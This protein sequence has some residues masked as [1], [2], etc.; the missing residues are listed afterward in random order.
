M[1]NY[2]KYTRL[3]A[4]IMAGFLSIILIIVALFY[5]LK[6]FSF[7]VMQIPGINN[8]YTILILLVP[9]IVYY[10]CYFY[11]LK[12]I[13]TTKNAWCKSVAL[14]FLTAG[15][16]TATTTLVLAIM[17]N[18]KFNAGWLRIFQSNSHYAFIAQILFLFATS[19]AIA[20]GDTKEK[21]WK[22]RS[23]IQL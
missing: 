18:Y 7:S 21:D 8:F 23:S 12:K 9:Y 6:L 16:I 4:L 11:L 2:N 17:V 19:I 15:V 13:G 14:F 10:C 3:L 20:S 5:V 22:E 1:N